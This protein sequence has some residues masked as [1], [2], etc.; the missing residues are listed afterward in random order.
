MQPLESSS[1]RL[2]EKQMRH[3]Y[4]STENGWVFIMGDTIAADSTISCTSRPKMSFQN[5][6]DRIPQAQINVADDRRTRSD[7]AEKPTGSHCGRAIDELDLPHGPQ[8]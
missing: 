8:R 2:V 3:A 5:T 6:F 7:I 4:A 1:K